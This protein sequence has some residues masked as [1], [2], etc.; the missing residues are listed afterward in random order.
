VSLDIVSDV[1][2]MLERQLKI[3]AKI[4]IIAYPEKFDPDSFMRLFN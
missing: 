4:K 2:G 1:I 3:A